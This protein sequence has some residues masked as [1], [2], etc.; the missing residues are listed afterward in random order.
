MQWSCNTVAVGLQDSSTVVTPIA[1]AE[2]D[3]GRA[4]PVFR[5]PV[6]ALHRKGSGNPEVRCE[7]PPPTM[8][9]RPAVRA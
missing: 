2:F 1:S 7:D 3:L 4:F 5:K 6:A 9:D 8:C